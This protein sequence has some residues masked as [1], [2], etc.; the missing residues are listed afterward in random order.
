MEGGCGSS[1]R[2]FCREV[3]VLFHFKR[4]AAERLLHDCKIEPKNFWIKVANYARENHCDPTLA[5]LMLLE[6]QMRSADL[7]VNAETFKKYGR[8]LKLFKG[9]NDWFSRI[10]QF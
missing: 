10:K 5:Y 3:E 4:L 1:K 6:Q 7:K 2:K 8:E 9:V